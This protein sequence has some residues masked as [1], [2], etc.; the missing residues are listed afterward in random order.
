MRKSITLSS[1][2][3]FSPGS[4]T[5]SYT[6]RISSGKRKERRDVSPSE[7]VIRNI[8]NYSMALNVFQTEETG[9]VRMVM[10]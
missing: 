2:T 9:I 1:L 6:R 3:P 4:K 5:G 10:N 7:S 8:L